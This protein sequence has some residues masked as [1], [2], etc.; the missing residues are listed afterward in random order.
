MSYTEPPAGGHRGLRLAGALVAVAVAVALGTQ[1]A[2]VIRPPA[3][4]AQVQG[5]KLTV[6]AAGD[7]DSIDPGLVYYTFG[8]MVANATQ[9]ALLGSPPTAGS[10]IVP[11]LASEPPQVSPDGLNVTVHIRRGVRFSPPVN[12]EVTSGDVKYAIERG[13]FRTVPNPYAAAYFGDLAGARSGAPPGSTIAGLETPDDQTL[14]LRL[15]KP[16]AGFVATALVMSLT[17]PVPPEYAGPFDRNDP[18]TYWSH[19]VATGPY[20]VEN[21]AQGNTVGYVPGKSIH[22][23]RNPNWDSATDYRPARLDDITIRE[24]NTNTTRASREIL[25]G[26]ALVSGDFSPPPAVLHSDVRAHPAQFTF[27]ADGGVNFAPLNTTLPPFTNVNVRRAVVA[28]FD[29]AAFLRA[30]GGRLAG[31]LGTHFI[32]PGVPGFE[33]AGGAR[34][35]SPLYA[36]PHGDRKLA[37]AYFR[38]AGFR[39][40]RYEGRRPLTLLTSND[41]IGLGVGRTVERSLRRLGFAVRVRAVSFDRMLEMCARPSSRIH[42]CPFDGWFR[43]FPD[44][45]TVID[46]LFNGFNILQDGNNNWSQLNVPKINQAIDAAKALVDPQARARAWAAIDKQI[47]DLAPGVVL[48]YPRWG[49]TRS[50]DVDGQVNRLLGGNWDLSFTALR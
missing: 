25:S 41:T 19:E 21:D 43:D 46:P 33:E 29:R 48:F 20:M 49:S 22:L 7:V 6:L 42:V 26:S 14:V 47:V 8:N 5:G 36:N 38:R 34:S 2:A 1:G 16:R 35:G 11:D 4:A 10:G 12:R 28:G 3:S 39:S 50:V 27:T 31:V 44:A 37:A 45:E 24:G 30:V 18:S 17:A 9:R 40:G 13:F 32:P 15:V 23:V